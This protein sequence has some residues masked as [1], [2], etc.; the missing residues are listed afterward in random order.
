MKHPVLV[1]PVDVSTSKDPII[2]VD[3]IVSWRLPI[4]NTVNIEVRAIKISF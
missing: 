3:V 2:D 4:L 1:L